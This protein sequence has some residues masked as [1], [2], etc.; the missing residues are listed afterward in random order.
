MHLNLYRRLRGDPWFVLGAGLALALGLLLLASPWLIRHDPYAM[1]FVPLSAPSA[2]HW[3]GVND[4][5]MDIWAE[6][7]TGF[8]N[9]L[10]FG[11]FTGLLGLGLGVAVGLSCAWFRGLY[12]LCLMRL[13]DLLL[14]IPAVL[15]LILLAAYLRPS[16]WLLAL[17]L[18]LMA[19]PT[20]AR[21]IRAQALTLQERSHLLAARQMG[22]S[23]FY[24]LG[25]HLL[26]E[27]F[28]LYL[29]GF[30]AL[31]RMAVF[32]EA[33]LSFL[34][35]FDPGRKSLG[36]MVGR[37]LPYYYLEIGWYWLLPP[38]LLLTMLLLSITLLAVSLEKIFDPR[39]K[40]HW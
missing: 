19:W 26:P 8:G 34:G 2:Q 22:G 13:A 23:S 7:L 29:I 4:G 27:L 20:S 32:M 40:E 12:D 5:G 16:A 39:L 11:L 35:L 1:D 3:L 18:A 24:L 17:V 30:A 31:V 21:V 38:V 6:L 28:P 25:R 36:M 14:A 15:V 9:T 37:A 10:I 33:S